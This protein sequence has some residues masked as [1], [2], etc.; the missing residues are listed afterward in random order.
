MSLL[1][2]WSYNKL[3]MIMMIY[4]VDNLGINMNSPS[5][6]SKQG[7]INDIYR[8]KFIKFRLRFLWACIF[9]TYVTKNRVT[10]SS[11]YKRFYPNS[12]E[13]I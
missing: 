11:K 7:Y 4:T 3:V 12:I 1:Y 8:L 9:K 5:K 13:L 2:L 10:Q 6:E